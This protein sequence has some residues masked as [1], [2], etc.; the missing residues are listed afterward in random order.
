[1]KLRKAF[2]LILV[3]NAFCIMFFGML[4]DMMFYSVNREISKIIMWLI[5]GLFWLVS[6]SM[7]VVGL[8]DTIKNKQDDKL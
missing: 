4:S 3:E 8:S 7:C 1:M 2:L 5:I 6:F